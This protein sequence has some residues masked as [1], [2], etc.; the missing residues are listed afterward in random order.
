MVLV[1]FLIFFFASAADGLTLIGNS[2]IFTHDPKTHPYGFFK[3]R[4]CV[5]K[6]P[7][8]VFVVNEP[9]GGCP[10]WALQ[11]WQTTF[12]TCSFCKA[13]STYD[14]DAITPAGQSRPDPCWLPYAKNSAGE[15]FAYDAAGIGWWNVA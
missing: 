1:S 13:G 6:T 9:S 10:T 15:C 11:S 14:A 8:T 7:T 5:P 3:T 4:H 2:A 12:D